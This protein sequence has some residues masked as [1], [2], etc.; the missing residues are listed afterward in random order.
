LQHEQLE[1]AGLLGGRGQ[2]VQR[3][4]PPASASSSP[5]AVTS[6]NRA[7]S[8]V[9]SAVSSSTSMLPTTRSVRL[10]KESMM[11]CSRLLLGGDIQDVGDIGQG[12]EPFVAHR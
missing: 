2:Q 8:P 6:S 5:A 4:T 11:S 7:Q 9:S 12:E 1:I 3:S 10:L